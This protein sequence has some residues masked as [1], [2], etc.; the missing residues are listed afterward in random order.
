MEEAPPQTPPHTPHA[1]TLWPPQTHPHTTH[2]THTNTNI[3]THRGG[4][5]THGATPQTRALARTYRPSTESALWHLRTRFNKNRMI[6]FAAHHRTNLL[7]RL[8]SDAVGAVQLTSRNMDCIHTI[9]TI[10]RARRSYVAT[11]MA[12]SMATS[13]GKWPSN[14]HMHKSR[15]GPKK[16]ETK[17]YPIYRTDQPPLPKQKQMTFSWC[18]RSSGRN[19]CLPQSPPIPPTQDGGVSPHERTPFCNRPERARGER[20]R[21]PPRH[22]RWPLRFPLRALFYARPPSS[23]PLPT[24]RFPGPTRCRPNPQHRK[25]SKAR[26]YVRTCNHRRRTKSANSPTLPTNPAQA[27]SP[28]KRN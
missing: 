1:Y 15:F 22:R 13:S 21:A 24:A 18:L 19:L 12:T 25:D 6:P 5:D 27:G 26:A 3:H 17:E 14:A 10:E 9:C 11:S 2:H 23:V 28:R 16:R 4:G 7:V 20:M 8:L